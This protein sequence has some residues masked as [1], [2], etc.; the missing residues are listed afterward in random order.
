MSIQSI[1]LQAHQ[2]F[3][4]IVK[5]KTST[6]FIISENNINFCNSY[7][8]LGDLSG[9]M[10]GDLLDV[11][12]MIKKLAFPKKIAK[13]TGTGERRSSILVEVWVAFYEVP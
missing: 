4:D 11:T 5:T 6:Y 8:L 10:L 9:D 13:P 12:Q 3:S 2:N 1:H 7:D